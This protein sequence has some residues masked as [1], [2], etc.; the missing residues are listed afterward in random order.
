ML[1]LEIDSPELEKA[2]SIWY[3]WRGVHIP[4]GMIGKFRSNFAKFEVF[5]VQKLNN[6]VLFQSH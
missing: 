1:H 6:I 2:Q 4:A 5:G 3:G